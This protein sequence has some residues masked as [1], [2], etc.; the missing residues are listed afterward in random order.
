MET[1]PK[2]RA[3]TATILKLNDDMGMPL[4]TNFKAGDAGAMN[5]M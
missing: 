3:H 1:L 4:D 2:I 5:G